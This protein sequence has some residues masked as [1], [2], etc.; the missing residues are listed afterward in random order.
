MIVSELL[1]TSLFALVHSGTPVPDSLWVR[2]AHDI[3]AGLAYLHS[4][5]P[6]IV[7]RDLSS[8]NVL[9]TADVDAL[10]RNSSNSRYPVAKIS[11]FGLSRAMEWYMTQRTGNMFYMAVEVFQG[12]HYTEKA[13]VRSHRSSICAELRAQ[14]N[15]SLTSVSAGVLLRHHH[16]RDVHTHSPVRRTQSPQSR[17]PSG[18]H[19]TSAHLAVQPASNAQEPDRAMLG[20]RPG[21]STLQQR[22]AVH[23]AAERAPGGGHGGSAD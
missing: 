19:W 23:L 8:S 22:C 16:E 12:E 15:N 7:H 5:S 3:A 1:H 11:D 20:T 13:D 14:S 17:V 10:V 21:R 18:V 9:L 6:P 2:I 4:R